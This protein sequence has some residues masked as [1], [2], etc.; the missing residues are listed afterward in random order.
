MPGSRIRQTP[1]D[2]LFDTIRGAGPFS[3]ADAGQ[4]AAHVPDLDADVTRRSP[5]ATRDRS[6]AHQDAA[7]GTLGTSSGPGKPGD[8]LGGAA[9]AR[10]APAVGR[11]LPGR[12]GLVLDRL[13]LRRQRARSPSIDRIDTETPFPPD[14]TFPPN[15]TARLDPF[16][17][18]GQPARPPP[19]T[20]YTLLCIIRC[21]L[22]YADAEFTRETDE[23][24]AHA[25]T[26]YVTARRLL[27]AAGAAAAAAG[28]PRRARRWRSRNWTRCG[29]AP[30]RSW[31]SCGRAATSP[32]SPAP[33]AAH[34]RRR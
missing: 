11:G 5:T 2:K 24:I 8:L 12:A 29:P 19:Y 33:R 4:L 20:R 25:R 3:A 10:P 6:A 28:Q 22:D 23:S 7:P 9:A 32:A 15:W 1:L 30:R 34:A 16:T 27:G 13:P 31:P 18:V 26:L 21:H 14:L 17:L